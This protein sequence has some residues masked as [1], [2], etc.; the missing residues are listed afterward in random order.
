[1]DDQSGAVVRPR[2]LGQA[3][4]PLPARADDE[5]LG[6][7]APDESREREAP[8]PGRPVG[9]EVVDTVPRQP[10]SPRSVR[11]E[12]GDLE[13]AR[14]RPA[15]SAISPPAG[16]HVG[17]ASATAVLVRR[18]R[19]EPSVSI[20][21]RSSRSSASRRTNTRRTPAGESDGAMFTTEPD[22]SRSFPLPSPRMTQ[23]WDEDAPRPVYAIV[24]AAATPAVPS[25]APPR[26]SQEVP[27]DLANAAPQQKSYTCCGKPAMQLRPRTDG[28]CSP[29][30]ET[31]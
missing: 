28:R 12:H 15:E 31:A 30:V 11:L 16:D 2:P 19:P 18:R 27:L 20:R 5:D 1:M 24:L 3:P 22:V 13:G 8:A 29:G 9:I 14:A 7:R 26:R 6:V 25:A 17:S 23:T 10:P 4:E 21:K